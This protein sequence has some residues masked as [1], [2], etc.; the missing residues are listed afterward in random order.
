MIDREDE[1][2]L[3]REYAGNPNQSVRNRI[4]ERYT[5]LAVALARRFENRGEPLEDLI[6]VASMALVGAVERFDPQQGAAFSSFATPTILGELK[7]HFRDKTWSVKV[8]RGI[9]EL[10]LRV[11]PAVAE[12]HA[13]LGR[14]P[15]IPE[16]AGHLGV[17]EEDVIEAMEAGAAYKPGALSAPDSDGESR[18]DRILG[19]ED[20]EYGNVEARVTVRRL[21]ERLP[22]RERTIVYL[23][24]FEDLTQSEIADRIGVSQVHVSRLLREALAR[25]LRCR[26]QLSTL[27]MMCACAI[28]LA[29]AA[30]VASQ[31]LHAFD[32]RVRPSTRSNE[33]G[34]GK[35]P[36]RTSRMCTSST[37]LPRCVTCLR[38]TPPAE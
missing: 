29:T 21:M 14:G 26:I 2:A 12:L 4:V 34:A 16:L 36:S 35:A 23:R 11:G 30:A 24:Y 13:S 25:L 37:Q 10:H 32:D 9:K 6:Q 8:P 38:C 19:E 7:R 5:G 31:Q 3:F 17:A 33:T 15:T 27:T 20:Q 1:D 28:V 18:E 22:E